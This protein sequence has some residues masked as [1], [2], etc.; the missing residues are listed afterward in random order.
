MKKSY[1]INILG[2]ELTVLSDAD[3][4]HVANVI[5]LLTD[6]IEE[7]LKS[8]NNLKAL[9]VAILAALN[10]AEE[11]LKLRGI[12]KELCDQLET[13]SEELIQLIENAS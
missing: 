13:R 3:D 9:D 11:L 1:K 8:A 7:V 2:Q 6:N 4:E 10:V 12:N 5:K